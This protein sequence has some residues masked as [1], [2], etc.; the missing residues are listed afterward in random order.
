MLIRRGKWAKGK[1]E[2]LSLDCVVF[3]VC[4]YYF[5]R[6]VYL[7]GYGESPDRNSE[8]YNF[9]L[10]HIEAMNS[11]EDVLKVLLSVAKRSRSP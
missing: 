11:L 1:R 2:N 7:C 9:R 4:I 5:Q 10:D 6:A 3:P 8:W